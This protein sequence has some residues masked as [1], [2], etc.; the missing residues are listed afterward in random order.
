MTFRTTQYTGVLQSTCVEPGTANVL[1]PELYRRLR[2]LFNH[3]DITNRGGAFMGEEYWNTAVAQPRWEWRVAEGGE[4]YRVNCPFC[5]ET[6]GRL[7][8][9]HRFGQF[10][11]NGRR[12]LHLATCY[13]DDHCLNDWGKRVELCDMIFGFQ[14]RYNRNV[15]FKYIA[16]EPENLELRETCL[17]G[18][19]VPL[20]DLPSGHPA[21]TYMCGRRGY[22]LEFLVQQGCTYCVR[23]EPKWRSAQ[24]R[25]IVPIY[26]DGILVGWQGRWPDELDWKAAGFPK[27]YT[28]PG[29]PKRQ[30]LYNFDQ[31]KRYPFVIVEEGITDVWATGPWSVAVLGS[32]LTYPQQRHLLTQWSGRPIVVMLDGGENE[33]A[34][35]QHM[36]SQLVATE[37]QRCPV[38]YVQLPEGRDPGSYLGYRE[39]LMGLVYAQAREKGISLP[40]VQ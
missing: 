24:G 8:I 37:Q 38:F 20:Q 27:Y 33:R 2:I 9:S 36:V 29:M 40:A 39:T 31:A 17:P 21:I 19:C 35:M 18:E 7:I 26:F 23:A 5:H 22:L 1:C 11:S 15:Q 25:V 30:I 28:L 34:V 13:N 32:A 10:D 6:R 16:G 14:N 12:M 4:H 3:V